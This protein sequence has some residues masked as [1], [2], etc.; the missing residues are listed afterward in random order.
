M[1][2]GKEKLLQLLHEA[3][4]G[5]YN[6]TFGYLREA[7]LFGRKLA[8]GERLDAVFSRFSTME[9]NH[10]DAVAAKII[11]LGGRPRWNFGPSETDD[12]LRKTLEKHVES[13]AAAYLAYTKIMELC[14]LSADK[15][16][17]LK[18]RAIRNEELLHL[19]K[20]KHILKHL[21]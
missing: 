9:L 1:K 7:S 21:K 14:A 6:D 10:A 15:D 8:G 13:E 17:A 19:Q 20:V 3:F 16:F 2:G 4:E 12:S 5:E 11:E 18:A